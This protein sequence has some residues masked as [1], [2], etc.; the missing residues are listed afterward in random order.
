MQYAD[1]TVTFSSPG[2]ELLR[3]VKFILSC[4]EQLSGTR[5]DFH[6]S[7]VIAMNLGPD[8]VDLTSPGVSSGQ[9]GACLWSI[10]V[11][12][13]IFPNLRGKKQPVVDKI[14]E[15]PKWASAIL[16]RMASAH[17]DLLNEHSYTS[18]IS[19]SSHNG[20]HRSLTLAWLISHGIALDIGL[21]IW[22]AVLQCVRESIYRVQ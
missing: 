18:S 20:P 19:S 11:C 10:S 13:F 5:I 14:I 7:E 12:L 1:N 16:W 2:V 21:T 17:Q 8:Q 3:K 15:L 22:L 4:F 9:W 6:R